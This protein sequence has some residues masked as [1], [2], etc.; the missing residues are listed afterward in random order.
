ML[1]SESQGRD[2]RG[3]EVTRGCSDLSSFMQCRV[4][5][6]GDKFVRLEES[7]SIGTAIMSAD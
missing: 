1:V 3:S 6:D 5:H 2:V 4:D 7:V